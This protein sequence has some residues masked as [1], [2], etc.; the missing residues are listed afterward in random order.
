[1]LGARPGVDPVTETLHS[2]RGDIMIQDHRVE[3]CDPK[4]EHEM[5][6]VRHKVLQ[7]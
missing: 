1:M 6:A 7:H 3:T 2:V 4:K 5:E